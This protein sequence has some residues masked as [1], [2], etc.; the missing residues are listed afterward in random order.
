[1]ADHV[2]FFDW[3]ETPNSDLNSASVIYDSPPA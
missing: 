2:N 1:M 3:I